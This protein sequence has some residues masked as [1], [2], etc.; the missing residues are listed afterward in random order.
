VILRALGGTAGRALLVIYG[1]WFVFLSA[2]I[3]RSGADRFIGTVYPGSGPA[4]FIV[5]TALA[6]LPAVLGKLKAI[7][8]SA[9]IF[10]PI[11]VLVLAVVFA[12][13]LPRVNL[14][15]VWQV[16]AANEADVLAG[17]F[18]VFG[19]I[20]IC[21]YLAFIAH[22]TGRRLP[23]SSAIL[24][25][26]GV[27]A[28]SE[29]LCLTT[30]GSFGA[31][32]TARLRNPFFAMVRDI[33]IFGSVER[34]DAPIV[35]M[36][37]FS[38]FVLI[39]LLLFMARE[40][41][42]LV[43]SRGEESQPSGKSLALVCVILASATALVMARDAVALEKFTRLIIPALNLTFVYAVPTLVLLIGRLRGKL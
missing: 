41:L 38:D 36:W 21:V 14:A 28:L 27:L 35:A 13:S 34:I 23:V 19:P 33:S 22:H 39:S 9:M 7:A 25:I 30:I 18:T 6:C 8:R 11:L 3:L 40:N 16:T 5:V 10:R 20:S 1:A 29:L 4:I 31:E 43:L 15:G 24:W 17:S 42:R 32:M 26:C 2:F 37:V 12:F